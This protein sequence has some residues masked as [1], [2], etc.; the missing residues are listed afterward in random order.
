[1]GRR[2][3]VAGVDYPGNLAAL[4][5]WF[6]DDA[7]CL[8][9]LDWLRWPDGFRCTHCGFEKGWRLPGGGWSCGGCRRR[10]RVLAGTVFQDTRTPLTVWFE[11]AWLMAV[12]KNGVSAASLQPLLGL[13]SY[14]TAWAMCHKL[15]T[16][17]GRT[18][19]DLL[20]GDVEVDETFIGGVKAGGK[21]GRGAPGKA[22]V[23]I[24]VE[25]K[26]KAFGRARL[27]V[28]PKIDAAHLGQ[29]LHRH[30]APG[31]VIVSDALGS[32]PPAIADAYGHKP[33]KIKRSGLHAHEVMP[34]VHRVASLLK[35]WL[36][37]THQSGV[38]AEHLQAYLDEFTFRFNRRHSRAR[39]LLFLRLLEGCVSAPPTT[40]RELIKVPNPHPVRTPPPSRPTWSGSL[41]AE[42]LDR[43]WR[44]THPST[45][46]P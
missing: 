44:D 42:P 10:V 11:A 30:I 35:R 43:P 1:M 36:A 45:L 8:D 29:F 16:G 20:S 41:T 40:M 24:G 15:R 9:Y 13:G 21:R 37:G 28:V 46:L 38:S 12:T 26:D 18:S 22:Y 4:R 2:S 7:A 27:E 32:Y 19:A 34:G 31:S 23:V 5:A 14:E 39:G 6:P 3:P 33:F 25:S 17:M